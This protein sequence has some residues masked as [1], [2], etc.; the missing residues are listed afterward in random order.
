MSFERPRVVFAYD[1]DGTL[2]PGHM[3]NHAFI[4]DELGMDRADFWEEVRALAVAQRGDEILAYMHVMLTKAQERGLELSLESWRRRGADLKLFPG[5]EAWFERQNRRA[6]EL[7]LDLRHFIISSGNRELIEGSPIARHFERIYASAFIFDAK[8][9]AVGI[10]LG[11]NYTSKTQY[12]FRINKWTLEE[13]D[14][15]AINR[16]LDKDHR[17]VPFDRI[18]YFGDGF[19]DIPTMRLVT[20]QGGYAVAVYH[21]GDPASEA[22]ALSLRKDG[23]AHLAGP[24]DYT[25]GSA[26][27][28]LATAMLTEMAARAHA[29]NLVKWPDQPT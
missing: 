27:D 29:Q 28:G 13:W 14:S 7:Q 5:V 19:T 21:E 2:A 18:V 11:V 24:G 16:S 12:L 26:L 25:E 10:A 23:R 4:P 22:A 20:D 6:E 15:V 1:F 9:E 8:Q 17:P 3:Q